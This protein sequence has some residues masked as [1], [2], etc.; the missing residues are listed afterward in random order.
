MGGVFNTV[1]LHLYHYAGNNPV[2][3]TNPDGRSDDEANSVKVIIYYDNLS[4]DT[5][6]SFKKAAETIASGY[7]EKTY[8]IGVKSESEFKEKWNSLNSGLNGEKI[9]SLDI[10]SH[11]DAQNLYFV[12]DSK[13]DGSLTV[14]EVA[15][16]SQ[17]NFVSSGEINLNSC[18]SG[19]LKDKGIGQGFADRQKVPVSGQYG[20]S[21]FSTN[22]RFYSKV[23][24]SSSSIYLQ[25]YDRGRN[26]PWGKGGVHQPR[27]YVPSK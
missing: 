10:L 3:Y 13:N 8:M 2:T 24:S 15:D 12:G 23:D 21:S 27:R 7:G 20:F 11:G 22:S 26:N 4:S 9:A 17:L 6:G 18:N 1:N 19:S 16:L 25:S 5:D 14:D